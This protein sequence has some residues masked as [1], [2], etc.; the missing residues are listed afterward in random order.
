[1]NKNLMII[2]IDM[3]QAFDK[4]PRP[5]PDLI[6]FLIQQSRNRRKLVQPN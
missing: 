2:S 3:E 4:N 6:F 1:M 5:I